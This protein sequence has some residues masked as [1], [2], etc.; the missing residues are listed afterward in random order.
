MT[1]VSRRTGAL[2]RLFLLIALP[3]LV[4]LAP[5]RPEAASTDLPYGQGLLWRVD[6]PGSAPS[7]VFGTM[8]SAAKDVVAMPDPVRSSLDASKTVILEIVMNPQVQ[9][10]LAQSMLFFDGR[11]LGQVA[12][13]ERLDRLVAA[14]ARY[15]MGREQIQLFK[16]WA[17]VLFFSLPPS[18]FQRQSAGG[19]PLDQI[20][21]DTAK[22][23]G[24]A[25]HG[26]ETVE[27]QILVF[28][29]L[30]EAD[31]L[32][33][34]DL[35][36]ASHDQ[37]EPIFEEMKAAYLARDL[38]RLFDLKEAMMTDEVPLVREVFDERMLYSRNENMAAR[39]PQRLDAGG[40][41]VAVGALHLPGER[42]VL[43][44]L[45]KQGYK[46]TRVY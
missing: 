34:L 7:Y 6:V 37:I 4:L 21:Q 38:N 18:E 36:V 22:R 13:T 46:L 12:G 8:H 41:F 30:A 40:A 2:S 9:M 19:K 25:V 10:V 5:L 32:E 35:T 45:E 20:I 17:L 33:L 3:A 27:E 26:L 15:G 39:L 43:K 1:Q 16:P 29:G 11:S 14:G 31:Q 23:Q 42:G 44:L 24:K 28:S